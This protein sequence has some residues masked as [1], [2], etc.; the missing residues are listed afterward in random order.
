MKH[1]IKCGR[2]IHRNNGP[3]RGNY[4]KLCSVLWRIDKLTEWQKEQIL[5]YLTKTIR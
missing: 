5:K 2:F 3:T 1:C 4:C